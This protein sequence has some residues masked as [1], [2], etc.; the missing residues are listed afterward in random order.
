MAQ[1]G[2][3]YANLAHSLSTQDTASVANS[4][5]NALSNSS[6]A[7]DKAYQAGKNANDA[8]GSLLD[9]NGTSLGKVLDH[10]ATKEANENIEANKQDALLQAEQENKIKEA[11]L[12]AEYNAKQNAYINDKTQQVVGRDYDGMKNDLDAVIR[13]KT[14]GRLDYEKYMFYMNRPDLITKAQQFRNFYD[15]ASKTIDEKGNLLTS[16]MDLK[17][18][19]DLEELEKDR[20]MSYWTTRMRDIE[21][22][23][24]R[25]K[26]GVITEEEYH[27]IYKQS[28]DNAYKVT[29]NYNEVTFRETMNIEDRN[30]RFKTWASNF[31]AN[32]PPS[33]WRENVPEASRMVDENAKNSSISAN[34]ILSE[35]PVNIS[36]EV[37]TDIDET[38]LANDYDRNAIAEIDAK[39]R[40]LD[41]EF[42]SDEYKEKSRV[43]NG[44]VRQYADTA[45]NVIPSVSNTGYLDAMDTS[46]VSNT[47]VINTAGDAVQTFTRNYV[48]GGNAALDFFGWGELASLG[49]TNYEAF[50]EFMSEGNIGNETKE[51]IDKEAGVN[52]K[53]TP[54]QKNEKRKK[55]YEKV[56][57][58]TKDLGGKAGSGIL[59]KGKTAIK[60]FGKFLGVPAEG[61]QAIGGVEE[62][63]RISMGNTNAGAAV[64]QPKDEHEAKLYDRVFKGN[65]PS[66]VMTD[67]V[68]QMEKFDINNPATYLKWTTN[69]LDEMLV[70]MN[71][72]EK[73]GY[74]AV[75]LG[76]KL[77]GQSLDKEGNANQQLKIMR[78]IV[79]NAREVV[80]YQNESIPT[81]QKELL[82]EREII[83]NTPTNLKSDISYI[84]AAKKE[85]EA[86]NTE[87]T[88]ENL[89][90][91]TQNK[92]DKASDA[93]NLALTNLASMYSNGM[94][95]NP[96]NI[97]DDQTTFALNATANLNDQTKQSLYNRNVKTSNMD[98]ATA[99][100]QFSGRG[101]IFDKT[102]GDQNKVL[103]EK[104][105]QS[106]KVVEASKKLE[107]VLLSDNYEGWVTKNGK[108]VGAYNDLVSAISEALEGSNFKFTDDF[109]SMTPEQQKEYKK[110]EGEFNSFVK[111]NES[112]VPNIGQRFIT[113]KGM[114]SKLAYNVAKFYSFQASVKDPSYLDFSN[115]DNQRRLNNSRF[116]HH[117]T[118]GGPNYTK[119]QIDEEAKN[120]STSPQ[121]NYVNTI[122]KYNPEVEKPVGN[123]NP[124]IVKPN[125]KDNVIYKGESVTIER[126]KGKNGQSANRVSVKGSPKEINKELDK[127]LA[128]GVISKKEYDNFYVKMSTNSIDTIKKKKD[129][130]E[131]LKGGDISKEQYDKLLNT[132]TRK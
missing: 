48:P 67:L 61:I 113:N 132:L 40:V 130:E 104:V 81:K 98:R 102:N 80:S 26:R 3:Y 69:E 106:P 125:K 84:D 92:L 46:N 72:K 21:V 124:N 5:A 57:D 32:V 28:R 103:L 52:D 71:R 64:Y 112:Y 90:E 86:E 18:L 63:I 54:E 12:L 14:D 10:F 89:L 66:Q 91:L 109:S 34:K 93:S 58:K 94:E 78:Q 16:P 95:N 50:K 85:A 73:E 68:Y 60:N 122:K 101:L 30:T 70:L 100:V 4:I 37:P 44:S 36:V 27:T 11:N 56:R 118:M 43:V 59:A 87:G 42:K 53:D 115:P 22:E 1:G 116:N 83:L 111:E 8:F 96:K 62:S 25:I 131:L 7:I 45:T 38:G 41:E 123:K 82:K 105:S 19:S 29:K 88:G 6:D 20:N 65:D 75:T 127:L 119:G 79:T 31:N 15:N 13:E 35:K 121:T 49:L 55:W 129:L 110:Q 33:L 9:T 117:I 39:A 76:G 74:N 47:G 126:V 107:N 114:A 99:V 128:Q 2:N 17:I 97:R 51:K 77:Q 24:D 108:V 120:T 23:K